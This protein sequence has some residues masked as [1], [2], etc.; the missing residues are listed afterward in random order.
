M[1]T[2]VLLDDVTVRRDG[3]ELVRSIDWE[4]GAGE[5]WVLFGPN[6]S[7]KTTLMEVV[8]TYVP[9]T[10]G[11]VEV[12]GWR[13]GKGIDV[14]SVRSRIGYVGPGPASYLRPG[15]PALEIVVTGLHASFVG[16]DWHTYDDADW[17]HA[18]QCLRTV[19]AAEL[20]EREFNTLSE[21]ERKRVMIA[22]SLMPRPD[23]LLLDEPGAGLDL[24]AREN[25]VDS[26]TK[27]AADQPTTTMVL[28]TH[29]VEEIPPGFDQLHLLGDGHTVTRGPIS[30]ALTADALAEAFG[31][32]VALE[33][34]DGRFMAHSRGPA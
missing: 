4:V 32:S 3:A 10:R 14:R 15:F 17:E 27:L 33:R 19:N 2:A 18:R 16:S 8:S 26:L 7:G 28:V 12:L 29:H 1:T 20:A 23:L 11:D 30:E 31:V 34:I 21:G 9:P 24:G 6:G 22:R 5:R 25:L 13:R